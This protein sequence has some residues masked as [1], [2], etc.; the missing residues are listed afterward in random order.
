MPGEI[1][2]LRS[3]E[4]IEFEDGY[5]AAFLYSAR[6]HGPMGAAPFQVLIR[7]HDDG[8]VET[9][10]ERT[11][12]F[13]YPALYRY[14]AWWISPALYAVREAVRDLFAPPLPL[15]VADPAH[16][17]R[18]IRCLA[19]VLAL[20]SLAVAAWRTSGT[21]LSLRGRLIWIVGCGLG[22][23]PALVTLWLMVP[24]RERHAVGPHSGYIHAAS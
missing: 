8:R 15:Y 2:D 9:I 24:L 12:R 14:R 13:D 18:S 23:L 10:H 17:P 19:A 16:I 3:L 1:G 5:L 21:A 11:L 6:S 7:A 22:G 20:L 4:F